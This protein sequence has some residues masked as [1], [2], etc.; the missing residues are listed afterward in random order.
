MYVGH[1]HNYQNSHL[2]T[3]SLLVYDFNTV[4][5]SLL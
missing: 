4:E 2:F 1:M 3:N 5:Q